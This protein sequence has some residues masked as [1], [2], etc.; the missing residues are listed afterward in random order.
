MEQLKKYFTK[1]GWER[2]WDATRID[3]DDI[4]STLGRVL[5][6]IL[7]NQPSL[8]YEVRRTCWERQVEA[9]EQ[10]RRQFIKDGMDPG[11]ASYAARRQMGLTK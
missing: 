7:Y 4:I 9:K 2:D 11:Y 1:E 3:L 10:L 5:D 6:R 8:S